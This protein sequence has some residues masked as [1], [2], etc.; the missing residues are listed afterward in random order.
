[1]LVSSPVVLCPEVAPLASS[2]KIPWL[3]SWRQ[4]AAER[5]VEFVHAHAIQATVWPSSAAGMSQKKSNAELTA[6]PGTPAAG[7]VAVVST[8]SDWQPEPEAV[9]SLPE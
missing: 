6:P 5:V 2:R 1:M 4:F 8:P 3:T 9:G 7:V